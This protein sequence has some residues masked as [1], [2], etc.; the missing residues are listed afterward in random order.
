MN[1]GEFV[2]KENVERLRDEEGMSVG[3]GLNM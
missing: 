3:N 2:G 1:D